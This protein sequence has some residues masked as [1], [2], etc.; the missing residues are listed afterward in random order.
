VPSAATNFYVGTGYEGGTIADRLDGHIAETIVFN[1]ELGATQRTL[2]HNY[3]SAKYGVGLNPGGTATD[4]YAGDDGGNGDYDLGA[5]GIGQESSTNFHTAAESDGLRFESASGLDDG[6]YL[7]AGHCAAV[8]SVNTS[9]VSGVSGLD[10]RL[11]RAWYIDVTDSGTG[12]AV[13]GTVDLSE[14]GLSGPAGTAANYVLMQRAADASAGT[15]WSAVQNGADDVT[16]DEVTF[17]GISPPDGKELTLGTTD[18]VN[19]PVG[20][21][22]IVLKGTEGNES[23]RGSD[24]GDAGFALLGPP[25]EG[26]TFGGLASDTDPQVIEFDIPGPM[27]YTYDASTDSWDEVT[28]S[29]SG[30]AMTNGE[31]FLFYVFDDAGYDDA[32]PVDPTLSLTV[33]DGTGVPSSDVTRNLGAGYTDN[34]WVFLANPFAVPFDLGSITASGNSQSISAY[35]TTVQVWDRVNETWD[36]GLTLDTETDMGDDKK[37]GVA[38]G[39]FL[40]CSDPGGDNCSTQVTLPTSGRITGSRNV[41]GYEKST[42]KSEP[43]RIASLRLS[44]QVTQGADTVA[45]DRAAR[46]LFYEGA[47]DGWDRYDATKLEPTGEIEPLQ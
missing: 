23:G 11:E 38:Q 12:L 34:Q 9:D 35:K 19:S 15:N 27:I 6:N 25:E 2:V 20:G 4:V 37:V 3:L 17:N 44:M 13:D 39:F 1:Q 42:E 7:M 41:I 45:R 18:R 26:G 31:G 43:E 28:G 21:A 46:V 14:A 32:D 40:E 33:S 29:E 47:T 22:V 16:G 5:F 8:D 30:N 10:A 36:P 24:G